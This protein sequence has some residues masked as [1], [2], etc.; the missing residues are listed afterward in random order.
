ML[1]KDELMKIAYQNLTE[2]VLR[3]AFVEEE[4]SP[5]FIEYLPP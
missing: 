1:Q 3:I 5:I 4:L 2:C